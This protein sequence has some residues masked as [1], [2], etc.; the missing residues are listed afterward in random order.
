MVLTMVST[1]WLKSEP[2]FYNAPDWCGLDMGNGK[3]WI[4]KEGKDAYD[5]KDEIATMRAENERLRN[6]LD[7]AK[8]LIPAHN[9]VW[10]EDVLESLK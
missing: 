6:M 4:G 10:H 7:R 1:S 3:M 5:G 2:A 8:I 9:W